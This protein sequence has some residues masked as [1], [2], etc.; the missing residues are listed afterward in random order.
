MTRKHSPELTPTI[1]VVDDDPDIREVLRTVLEKEGYRAQTANN[2]SDAMALIEKDAPDLV[3]LDI[4]MTTDTEGF[5]IMFE[6]QQHPEL[7]SIPIILL[8]SFLEKVR[9]S[10]PEG[11][12]H[13]VD[14]RWG[15][16]WI[17][18]KPIDI[19]RLTQMVRDVLD[20]P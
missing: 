1:L 14:E 6:L 15:A 3:I 13:I 19:R 4:M 7:K 8:T 18:E 2:G 20:E 17:F 10:G 12:E 5:D 9:S 11:F 16:K